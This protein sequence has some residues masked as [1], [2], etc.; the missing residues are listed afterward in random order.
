MPVTEARTLLRQTASRW[1]R[2]D[3]IADT[4]A[5]GQLAE[6][7][8]QFSPW[9][10]MESSEPADSLLLDVTG[11]EHL[12]DGEMNLLTHLQQAFEAQNWTVRLAIAETVGAAWALTHGAGS[13]AVAVPPSTQALRDAVLPLPVSALRIDPH[14]AETLWQL[15]LKTIGDITRLPRADLPSRFAVKT[16]LRLDQVFGQVAESFS[17]IRPEG[18]IE[19]AE[20]FD[21]PIA[22]RQTL[23]VVIER[24]LNE[25]LE[26]VHG[27]QAGITQLRLRIGLEKPLTIG[28]AQPTNLPKHLFGVITSRLERFRLAGPV[29]SVRLQVTGFSR[30]TQRQ[31]QLFEDDNVKAERIS[32]RELGR[33]MDRLRGRLDEDQ[34][35]R[36]QL[37]SDS[38]PEHAAT[39]EPITS[40]TPKSDSTTEPMPPEF[41]P[42]SRPL[43]MLAEPQ[44]LDVVSVY[45]DGPPL[46]LRWQQRNYVVNRWWGPERIESGWWRDQQVKRDYYRVETNDG[47]WFW[48]FR[49][50]RNDGWYLHGVFD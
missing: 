15:G 32:K 8:D 30:F 3:P 19:A 50:N 35:V 6:W 1:E 38:L 11:C 37:Q 4:H 27:V 10:G 34:L 13:Q 49:N 16:V 40:L 12:Y 2:F 39:F 25:V 28:F 45:P 17:P 41:T 42:L 29:G 7:C 20:A 21:W 44:A 36:P 26:T 23:L 31:G 14:V 18:V 48:L 5:L 47:H 22:D 33:L 43:T 9:V 24:L 46:R